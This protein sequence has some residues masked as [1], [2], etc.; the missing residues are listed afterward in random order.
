MQRLLGI[1][2]AVMMLLSLAA[3]KEEKQDQTESAETAAISESAAKTDAPTDEQTKGNHE[4][5]SLNFIKNSVLNGYIRVGFDF[6]R[7][8]P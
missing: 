8:F 1:A 7:Y 5:I 2:L 4:V 6:F 3:C